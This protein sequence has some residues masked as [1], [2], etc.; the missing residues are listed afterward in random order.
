MAIYL[1]DTQPKPSQEEEETADSRRRRD[2]EAT[3]KAILDAAEELFT[4]HG[5]AATSISGVARKADV[6]KSLIHHHFGSKEELWQEVQDRHFG[7]YFD[8]QMQL[9]EQ[10]ESTETLLEESLIA[11]FRFLQSDPK[12]VRFMGW[13]FVEEED[14]Q[15]AGDPE[16]QLFEIGIRKI[17]EAQ[18]EGRIRKDLEPFFIIKTLIALPFSWFQSHNLTLSMVDSEIDGPGLDERYLRDMVKIFFEGVRAPK[19]VEP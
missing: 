13:R 17:K 1:S 9:L 8:I 12:T 10:S 4:C 11:Y 14:S 7:E 18:E 5:P 16:K 3:R 19:A 2:P 6:T 15:C